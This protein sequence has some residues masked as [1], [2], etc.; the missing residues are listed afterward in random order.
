MM[1]QAGAKTDG[2]SRQAAI[3]IVL[4]ACIVAAWLA[5]HVF[6][7]FFYSWGSHSLVTAPLL[8]ALSCWLYVGLFI[9]A[10]DCM[11]GSLVPYRPAYNRLVGQL[12]LALYAGFA[13]DQLNR[14]HHLHHR[15]SGTE[16][17][18]DF[19][20]RPPHG[21]ARWYAS[22]FAE[23]FGWTQIAI[24]SAV[25]IVYMLLLGVSY[26]NL[27]A[28]WA[29]PAI[30]SSLQLFYFGTYLPHKPGAT[31]FSDR[32]RARSNEW[33]WLASLLT[34]FHF[35]YHHEHHLSP[36]VPWWQLLRLRAGRT[37]SHSNAV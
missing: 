26:S 16:G 3:G 19:D 18:P 11:H 17:D 22:F 5:A 28:F 9:V 15:H 33:S 6:G 12:C 8:V 7:V 24:L 21:F 4:A 14:K 37:G 32:H 36:D 30:A 1:Q 35:G 20:P 29:L 10:H 13:F 31:A 34:C 27:V 23:Y 25:S 2:R